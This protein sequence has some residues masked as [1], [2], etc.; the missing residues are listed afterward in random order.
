MSKGIL[1]FARNNSQVDYVKQAVFLAIRAKEYLN[2]PVSIAT[3]AIDYVNTFPKVFDQ[4][5]SVPFREGK[6][7]KRYHNGTLV[8]KQ[9]EFKN[10]DRVRA[11][12]LTPYD[13]TLV[14][15]TDIIIGDDKY[16]HC[17]TQIEDL[18][19]YKTAYDLANFRDYSEFKYLY[20]AGI[21]FYWATCVF[22][23]KTKTNKI[24]FD[25]LQHIQ[26]NWYHYRT[27][28]Q[29]RQSTFRNDHAFSIG[30]HIMNGY[31]SG[32]FASAMPGKLFY[33]ADRD[34]LWE[35]KGNQY[36]FL[37]EKPNY[38]GEYTPIKFKGTIH[39]MNKFSLSDVIDKE[40]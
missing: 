16:L 4:I 29:I 31:Q 22:F 38:L 6:S 27:I 12:D 33:T 24:F 30:V 10:D 17:F 9:L 19:M 32:N 39:V 7:L 28:F 40:I 2:L 34:I 26:D 20:D 8:Q 13:E 15:D 3:D 37:I 18:L 11:Y 25:L 21:D 14:L 35:L 23:R 5:I 1:V 36:L